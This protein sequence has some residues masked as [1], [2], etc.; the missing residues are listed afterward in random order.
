[1][2]ESLPFNNKWEGKNLNEMYNIL[3]YCRD[4]NKA[5]RVALPVRDVRGWLDCR[6][7]EPIFW[8]SWLS[9]HSVRN[10]QD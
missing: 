3:A 10:N 1:M 4:V 2:R 7:L 8:T 9:R 6:I 5:R